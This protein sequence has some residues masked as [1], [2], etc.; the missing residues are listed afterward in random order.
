MTPKC[1][2]RT[3]DGFGATT[4]YGDLA[5]RIG[6]DPIEG[7]RDVGAAMGKN[8]V[9]IV[10]PCHRVLAAGGKL[11]GFSARGGA[12]TKLKLLT[13]EGAAIATTPPAPPKRAKLAPPRSSVPTNPGKW[14]M[15]TPRMSAMG[16]SIRQETACVSL[17]PHSLRGTL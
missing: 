11:G 14:V 6:A 13:I 9:P 3:P 15:P 12:S 2:S 16:T 4:T 5:K 1:T 8:P 7:A 17:A 10:V